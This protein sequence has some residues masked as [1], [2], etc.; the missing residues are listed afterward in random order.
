MHAFDFIKLLNPEVT[1]KESKVHM[2]THTGDDDPL[3]VYLDGKF[4]GWQCWQSRKNFER[5]FV[6]SLIA[7]K[8]ANRWLFAGVHASHG[9]KRSKWRG[10]DYNEYDLREDEKCSVFN[11]RMVV[12][13]ERTGRQ[14]YLCGENWADSMLL[15]HSLPEKYSIADFPGFKNVHLTRAELD[16]IAR[17]NIESWQSTL[18]SVAGVYL[19]SD[20]GSGQL[21]VGSASGEGGIWG[22]WSD[23]AA[24]GHGGNVE[25]KKL[26]GRKGMKR[27]AE[28]T[29]SVLEI[30]DTHASKE[31]ILE[32]EAHWKNVLMTR[33]H[34]L[35]AN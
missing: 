18:S 7:M 24:T 19:I 1:P 10:K 5:R 34:G 28:F 15:S 30:A 14:S 31:E 17:E 20:K 32:R 16:L 6:V 26:M 9:S 35:N 29:Y 33:E 12:A 8:A 25:L 27:A 21:Y 13:F 4:N 23:Y 22:R 3:D 11:G 2:A